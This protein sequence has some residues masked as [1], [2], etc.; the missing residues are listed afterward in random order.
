V[1]LR[2]EAKLHGELVDLE[3]SQRVLEVKCSSR[4]CGHAPGTVVLH[5]FDVATGELVD[6][7]QFKDPGRNTEHGSHHHAAAVRSA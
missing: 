7:V 5:R 3:D 6:T 2:C 4:F 1:Q